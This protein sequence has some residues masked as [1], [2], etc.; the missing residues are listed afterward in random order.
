MVL[1][2][3]FVN[4]DLEK[5]Y[6]ANSLI[7]AFRKCRK[8]TIWKQTVQQYESNLL[9]NTYHK[10]QE[11]KT[12]TYKQ[13]RPHEFNQ[14]ERGKVRHIKAISVADR[15]V[16]RSVC[17]NLLIP[18]LRPALIYDNGAS[19]KGKGIDFTRRRIIAHL[20]KYYRKYGTNK[21]YILLVDY[22]KYFDNIRHDVFLR[23]IKPYLDDTA[24]QFVD[25]LIE[26]FKVDVS[27]MS[28]EE[29]ANCLNTVFNSLEYE[30]ISKDLLTGLKF[31]GKSMGIGSQISQIAGV[32]YPHKIDNYCKIVAGIKFYGRYADDSYIIAPDKEFLTQMLVKISEIAREIGIT[33]NAKK[34]CIL[35]LNN[36]HFLKLHYSLLP[37]GK[38]QVLSTNETFRRERRKLTKLFH[39]WQRGR[40]SYENIETGFKSWL[41]SVEK[42]GNHY[43]IEKIK[44][45][46]FELFNKRL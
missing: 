30:H 16:Q 7:A 5:V 15:V 21:G 32:Y 41:G 35:P 20:E 44:N 29:Y 40:L 14:R 13:G 1:R 43:R 17:D 10:Q 24:Y 39:K 4:N 33:I 8:G 19:L 12:L 11:I 45:Y 42:Q 34:T 2:N 25:G 18:K 46:Y 22:S 27:Y 23:D 37:N 9:I 28:D 6:N 3:V 38:V 31:M 26:S 36:F